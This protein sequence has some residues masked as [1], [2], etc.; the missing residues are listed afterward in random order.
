MNQQH[1]AGSKPEE[2]QIL[3]RNGL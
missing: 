2:G 3:A 1:A